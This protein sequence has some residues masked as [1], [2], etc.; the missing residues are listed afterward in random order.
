[1]PWRASSGASGS[2]ANGAPAR[3]AKGRQERFDCPCH[4]GTTR[5]NIV[6]EGYI[7]MRLSLL[8]VSLLASAAVGGVTYAQTSK[9]PPEK[10]KPAAAPSAATGAEIGSFGLDLAGM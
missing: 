8:T 5:T 2:R 9:P 4:S 7:C 10:A 1:M 3:I 6:H